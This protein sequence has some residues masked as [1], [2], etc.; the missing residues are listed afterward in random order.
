M[1]SPTMVREF[2]LPTWK[3]WG[4]IIRGAGCPVYSLDSDG[5]VGELIPIWIEAGIN[6][7]DTIEVAAG[8]DILKYRRQFGRAMA[9]R[10]GVDKRAMAKGGGAIKSEI[11]RLRPL[12]EE[13]GYFPGCDHGIP[14]DVSWP[15]F[16]QYVGLLAKACGWL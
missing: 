15:N 1:I 6:V 8:N 12:I 14:H 16:V 5:Y 3:R 2:L 4:D 10:Q 13:G 11:D 9:F 7:C